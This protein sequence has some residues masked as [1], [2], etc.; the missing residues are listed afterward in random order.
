MYDRNLKVYS[1]HPMLQYIQTSVSTKHFKDIIF[2]S[3]PNEMRTRNQSYK[4]DERQHKNQKNSC[5][6]T[7]HTQRLM[8]RSVFN[9]IHGDIIAGTSH[10]QIMACRPVRKH[11]NEILIEI[12]IFSSKKVRLKVSS[13]KCCSVRL[14]LGI[15]YR[16]PSLVR[17]LVKD[18][19][20]TRRD[21]LIIDVI[22]D[23]MHVVRQL[24]TKVIHTH[25]YLSCR[26][27]WE[28]SFLRYQAPVP[29]SIFQSN[30]NFDENSERFSFGYTR[31]ITTIFCTRHE[32]DTVVTCAKYRCD[33]LR[34]FYTRVFLIFIEFRIR[35]KYA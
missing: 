8:R 16:M 34:I 22:Y 30:S 25:P 31:P 10:D 29:L 35:S 19:M 9:F 17:D 6:V 33:R 28:V 18:G 21:Y 3:R 7:S 15:K 27:M 24:W 4:D 2:H 5:I 11:F 26:Q 14:G 32:S 1:S 13:A 20:S 23:F 12:K